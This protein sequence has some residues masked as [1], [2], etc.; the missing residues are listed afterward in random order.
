MSAELDRLF[1]PAALAARAWRLQAESPLQEWERLASLDGR[2][3]K[4]RAAATAGRNVSIDVQVREDANG[5]PVLEGELGAT[6]RCVCQ[7]CLEEM[8]FELRVRPKLFFGREDQLGEAA[9]AAGFEH[10]ELAPGV[11]LRQLLEDEAL[12]SVP[13]FPVHERSEDCG[14]L[15]KKLAALEPA[16][17]GTSSSSPFAVLAELKRRN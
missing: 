14:A 3:A 15:A 8:P 11:T 9:T 13:A 1:E 4:D 6:L 16:A 7:R 5:V 10:C 12:L 2:A 17:G